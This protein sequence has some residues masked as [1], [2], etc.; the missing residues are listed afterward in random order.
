M[1]CS[2]C[3]QCCSVLFFNFNRIIPIDSEQRKYYDYHNVKIKH[4]G[5]NTIFEVH[6]KCSQLG[7]DNKCK[8]FETRPKV[9]Y[10]ANKDQYGG[11]KLPC[12]TD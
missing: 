1:V 6:T 10:Y 4:K 5:H 3:G 9:C 12:C 8:I 11:V 2:E 7:D